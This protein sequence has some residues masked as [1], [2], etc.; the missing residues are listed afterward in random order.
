MSRLIIDNQ[1]EM[2]DG[3]VLKYVIHIVHKGKISNSGKQYCYATVFN[4][5]VV[6]A[7]ILNKSSERLLIY[8]EQKHKQMKGGKNEARS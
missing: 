7:S 4:D 8:R 1:T 3:D 5:G 6:V 2:T